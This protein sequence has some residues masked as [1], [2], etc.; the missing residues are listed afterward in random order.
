VAVAGD[1]LSDGSFQLILEQ[2]GLGQEP[3]K[4]ERLVLT[5]GKVAIDLEA[6]LKNS[7]EDMSWLHIARVEQLYPF[8]EKNIKELIKRFNNL[9]EIVWVQEEPKN[10]GSWF[11]MAQ[12]LQETVPK[13][14]NIRYIGRPDRSSPAGGEP[15]VHKREQERIMTQTLKER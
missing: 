12:K 3:E 1:T 10:M 15:D 8:P 11:Y 4:V 14:L 13:K 5:T 2:E 9:K 7:D 6:E